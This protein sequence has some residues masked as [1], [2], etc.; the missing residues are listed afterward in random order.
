MKYIVLF[1]LNIN[2]SKVF[3]KTHPRKENLDT[4]F[5]EKFIEMK[6]I[7]D[8]NLHLISTLGYKRVIVHSLPKPYETECYDYWRKGFFS[9]SDCIDSCR[10]RNERN[11]S[12]NQWPGT[13]LNSDQNSEDRMT[14][15]VQILFENMDDDSRFGLSCKE[16]CGLHTECYSE[17]YEMEF[18]YSKVKW[19][20]YI[21]A[22][23]P[24]DIPDLVYTIQPSM[25][26]E[27]FLSYLG[28][29][30]SFWFGFSALML[31]EIIFKLSKNFRLKIILKQNNN[32]IIQN[33]I[34]VIPRH[35][36][37]HHSLHYT[38]YF[39]ARNIFANR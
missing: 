31:F 30:I 3:I 21:I 9:R 14:N 6:H 1:T 17:N 18:Q 32:N 10:K 39:Q 4:F 34:Y 37:D 7:F 19:N 15:A 11:I 20:S 38:R 28:S 36:R 35:G 24:S 33:P 27:E 26:F 22:I 29:Y 23:L 16:K 2:V 25:L 12:G 8:K 5:K 13:Y